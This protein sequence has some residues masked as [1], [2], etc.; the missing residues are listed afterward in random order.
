MVRFILY[1]V[2]TV[3]FL[4]P[5]SVWG[6][7]W[8]SIV[9]VPDHCI[10]IYFNCTT[11]VHMYIY[12][13]LNEITTIS[14]LFTYDM[15]TFLDRTVLTGD[16]FICI[17]SDSL[18]FLTFRVATSTIFNFIIYVSNIPLSTINFSTQKYKILFYATRVFRF[19]I[20]ILAYVGFKFLQWR[21]YM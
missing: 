7:M 17:T 18:G 21:Y 20:T 9:S 3:C 13:I 4:F 6:R 8:N 11:L 2:L 16:Q 19:R 5:V 15:L 14:F 12:S 1:V 10:F